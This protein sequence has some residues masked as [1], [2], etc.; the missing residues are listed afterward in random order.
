MNTEDCIH[1]ALGNADL[2]HRYYKELQS[3]PDYDKPRIWAQ[4]A[5]CK[6]IGSQHDEAVKVYDEVLQAH[7]A[8]HEAMVAKAELLCELDRKQEALETLS[9]IEPPPVDQVMV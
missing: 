4:L 5:A 9:R 3:H 1:R 7:P 6:C 8:H 2:A